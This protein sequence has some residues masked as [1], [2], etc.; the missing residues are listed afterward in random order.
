MNATVDR[1]IN[2]PANTAPLTIRGR[3]QGMLQILKFNRHF[4]GLMVVIVG[5]L[6]AFASV[7]HFGSTLRICAIAAVVMAMFWGCAS[8]LASHWIYDLSPICRW[9]WI[10]DLFDTPPVR[11]ANIHAGLDES[12]EALKCIFPGNGLA[13]DIFD[14]EAMT[15]KSIAAARKFTGLSETTTNTDFRALPFESGTLDAVFLIFA[16]HEL[17]KPHDRQA[18]FREV[19]RVLRPDGHVVLVEHLRDWKN[20]AAFG[21]GFMHFLP[22][23]QW[24]T[25][26]RVAELQVVREFSI[27]PFVRIF[28]IRRP[29]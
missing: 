25:A 1:R 22:R 23:S 15:E 17:R 16:A 29:Q 13:L 7:T 2:M 21:P 9:N 3:Y 28:V 20:F 18:F 19:C 11:W 24:L 8:L 12:S 14:P 4:Y 5:A 6:I 27:T 26:T 10:A